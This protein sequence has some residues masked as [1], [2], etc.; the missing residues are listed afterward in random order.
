MNAPEPR[1]L[2]PV[3]DPQARGPSGAEV[4]ARITKRPA[5]YD[6]FQAMRRVEAAE[7]FA[8][9][10]RAAEAVLEAASEPARA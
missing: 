7:R 5:A 9:V 4:I 1:N 6:L 10:V 8:A 3:V 2:D